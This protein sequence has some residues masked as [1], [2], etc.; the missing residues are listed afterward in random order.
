MYFAVLGRK[1]HQL[2]YGCLSQAVV[3]HQ[4]TSSTL[5]LRLPVSSCC[6]RAFFS[7][8]SWSS[9]CCSWVISWSAAVRTM[10]IFC[11]SSFSGILIFRVLMSLL[12]IDSNVLPCENFCQRG[13]NQ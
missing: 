6:I 8:L 12:F 10:A 13:S 4:A 1:H 7:C 2:A 11:C 3:C 9:F 5:T